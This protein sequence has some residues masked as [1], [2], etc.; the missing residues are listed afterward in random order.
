[1]SRRRS[2]VWLVL[3]LAAV[4]PIF[5][6]CAV[7]ALDWIG[8][9]FTGFL[10]LENGIA[11]SVGRA[12]WSHARYRSVPFAR[13][14]AVDGHP[15]S[16]G[17]EIHA[18]VSA[19]RVGKPIV[20]TFRKG[21]DIFRLAI[22]VRLFTTADF[23]D[24]C[25]VFLGVGLLMVL[26]SA[27]VVF[28]R[29]DA[30]EARALFLVCLG[31]GLTMITAPDEWAPY[32]FTRVYFLAECMVPPAFVHLALTY[33]Q[34]SALLARGPL[35]YAV[36]YLPFAGLAAALVSSIPEPSLFLPLLYTMNFLIANAG[37][38][39]LG[40]LVVGLIDG[41]QP[42]ESVLLS[43][44]AMLGSCLIAA[45]IFSTYPLLQRPISPASFAAP[46]LL[47]PL[48]EGFAFVRYPLEA[49]R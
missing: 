17:R 14:L 23:V 13:V 47:F 49:R 2:R 31:M 48:L 11:L 35:A 16:D 3:V 21:A 6:T 29:P 1:M 4:L 27:L 12:E 19:A 26:V 44:A 42:R 33:P 38:L 10:F 22:P 32:W 28:L 8:R 37:I 39:C 25:A 7:N 24:L 46:L 40:A 20:Y 36:L 34:R 9:P 5:G 41:V 15:V 30:P 43:L 18:Y 45:A